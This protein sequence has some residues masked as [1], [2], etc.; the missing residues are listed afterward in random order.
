MPVLGGLQ[1]VG[2]GLGQ[3]IPGRMVGEVVVSAGPHERREVG[4]RLECIEVLVLAEEALPFVAGIAPAGSPQ[5]VK[6]TRG[7]AQPNRYEL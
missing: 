1:L 2:V 7:D 4:H 6:V 3:P 5:R